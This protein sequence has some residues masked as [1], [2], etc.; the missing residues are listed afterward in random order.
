MQT[1]LL[2]TG[3]PGCG[4]TTLIREVIA[5]I[6]GPISGFYT[7]E[8]RSAGRRLGF[9]LLT[10]DGKQRVLAHVD[11]RSSHRVGKYCVDIA[12]LDELAVPA[13]YHGIEENGLVVIDEIGPM[14]ILSACFRQAVLEVL[15]RPVRVFGSIARRSIPFTDAIKARSNIELIEVRPEHREQ[16][17]RDLIVRL[18]TNPD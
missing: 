18:S 1:K 10:L 4:K 3:L 14:E 8:I 17:R 7:Q 15:E 13:L 11:I 6:P 5:Q 2:L 16:L 12:V 9:N